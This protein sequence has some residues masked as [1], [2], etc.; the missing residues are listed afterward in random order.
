MSQPTK[1]EA[2]KIPSSIE[3]IEGKAKKGNKLY[4]FYWHI[5]SNN[6]RAGRV[7]I[8]YTNDPIL[9]NHASIQIFL[10]KKS[11]GKGIGSIGYNEAC[12]KSG[13]NTIYAHMRKNNISSK[14]AAIAAGFVEVKNPKFI[15]L[16]MVWHN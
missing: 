6:V 12:K 9:G 4:D 7:Y 5:Y 14:K 2:S 8:N 1:K 15:Q 11:Q 16:V 3:L 13:L 10:N